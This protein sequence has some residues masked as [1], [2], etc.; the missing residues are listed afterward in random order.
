[1]ITFF[2]Y[3]VFSAIFV[4]LIGHIAPA[5]LPLRKPKLPRKSTIIKFGN[6]F[7]TASEYEEVH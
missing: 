7:K 2:S 6:H 5:M 3:S 4:S 1:M